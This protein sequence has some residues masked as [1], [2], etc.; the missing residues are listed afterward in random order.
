MV[1]R[2]DNGIDDRREAGVP[3]P[4]RRPNW[5]L[6]VIGAVLLLLLLLAVRSCADNDADADHA[7]NVA[8]ADNVAMAPDESAGAGTAAMADAGQPVVWNR[9]AFT[10]YLG[11]TEP[12]G[13]AFALDR[14]TFNSGSALLKADA[15]AQ[16]AEVAAALKARP[17][18]RVSLRGYAD[19]AGDAAANQALSEQ[20]TNA[21][22]NALV[23]AGA[24]EAQVA[25]A[26]ALGETGNA[27]V[28]ANRR[29][30]ITVTA[31]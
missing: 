13:R 29:V 27:A 20:R 16:I 6:W 28:E 5:L 18:A 8:D 11:G 9:E 15:K 4:R 14:V 3:P 12:V 31:R 23:D 7:G 10:T 24:S 22:R 17:T 21:V 1:D 25:A 26:Q 19:P 2:N 30:E